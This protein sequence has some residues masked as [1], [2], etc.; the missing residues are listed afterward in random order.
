[1][2]F[3]SDG[4]GLGVSR[5][6]SGR[7]VVVLG[8]LFGVDGVSGVW[9]GLV[10]LGCEVCVVQ[11][12]GFGEVERPAWCDSVSDLALLVSDWVEGEGF[13]D[14]CLVGCSFGGWV[15]AE[16]AVRRPG[17]LGSLVVVDGV[18]LKVGGVDERVFADVFALSWGEVLT[19]A[20]VDGN[21]G[22]RLVG[23]V[24]R[25]ADEVLVVARAQ[26]ALAVYG[27]RPYLH[28]PKL[29]RRLGRVSVP[30]LVVWGAEDGLALP[31][32]GRGF[33]EA[34]PG[35]R[36]VEVAGAGHLPHVERPDEVLRVLAGFLGERGGE[37]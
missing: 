4:V 33:A 1:M 26:E 31:V 9:D 20:F 23:V 17:W 7:P 29:G 32:V 37:V 21:L 36:F 13:E 14:V 28:D 10:S 3:V 2:S 27:W 24:G 35:A 11:L 12:P 5:R 8:G 6:G 16:L 15:A 30:S 19:R 18:G 22:E 25:S 34:I